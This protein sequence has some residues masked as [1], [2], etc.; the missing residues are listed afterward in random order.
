MA[1]KEGLNVPIIT[2]FHD[3]GI[4]QATTSF[5][6]FEGLAKKITKQ[7]TG[8]FAAEKIFQF[9]KNSINAFGAE[10]KQ[11]AVFSQTITNL[12]FAMQQSGI[13]EYITKISESTGILKDELEPAFSTLLRYTRNVSESQK[14]FNTALDVSAGSGKNLNEVATAIGK[15]YGGQYTALTRLGVGITSVDAKNRTFA[16][17][18]T[19]VANAFKG[20]S[21]AAADSYQGTL[22]RLKVSA[23]EASVMIGAGLAAAVASLGSAF[24]G[25]NGQ[26]SIFAK[27]AEK[28]F[29]VI[30]GVT[31]AIVN[32][33]FFAEGLFNPKNWFGGTKDWEKRNSEAIDKVRA[34]FA[35]FKK[36]ALGLGGK[37]STL[38]AALL[39]QAQADLALQK[40]LTAQKQAQLA[41]EKAKSVLTAASKVLDTQQAEIAA[42]M[43]NGSLSQDEI[44][45]LQLKKAL[46]DDNAT[47]AGNLAQQVLATQI[48]MLKL[49]QSDPFVSMNMNIQ[50]TI[51]SL[52]QMQSQLKNLG[53]TPS[54]G[55]LSGT[56]AAGTQ[57]TNGVALASGAIVA[58]DAQGFGVLA[59]SAGAPTIN[60][61][62]S[63]DPN[64]GNINAS[65]QN[66]SL[67]GTPTTIS[68]INQL[69][70]GY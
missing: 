48:N 17:N 68:R 13:V 67:Q 22:N 33:K 7:I 56:T 29:S 18:M 6:E 40:Q 49:Q 26:L 45:R 51:Q 4:K 57:Y 1:I 37:Q 53:I 62:V 3:K 19:I 64:N 65:T 12:G 52:I 38:D 36:D 42:A 11:A 70:S 9:G 15:A 60:V 39:K 5:I 43:L 69:L 27:I 63:V 34:T 59:P 31:E 55:G 23:H 2:S 32:I 20:D 44:T 30:Q 35:K 28:I 25:T 66:Q 46:L 10:S 16:Q 61:V 41:A 24:T 47:A 8:L 58:Q 50:E 14:L 21:K 54:T